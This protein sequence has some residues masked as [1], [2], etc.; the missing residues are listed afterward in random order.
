MVRNYRYWH[1]YA[2][3]ATLKRHKQTKQNKEGAV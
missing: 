2:M 1:T 3:D